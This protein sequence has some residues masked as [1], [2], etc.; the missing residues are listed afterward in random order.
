MFLH[1]WWNFKRFPIPWKLI[2]LAILTSFLVIWA[3]YRFEHGPILTAGSSLS[4][5][6]VGTLARFHPEHREIYWPWLRWPW[7]PANHFVQGLGRAYFNGT[8]GRDSY[9]LG[10]VYSGGHWQFYPVAFLVKT[11]IALLLFF[12]GGCVWLFGSGKWKR[13][14]ALTLLITGFLGPL[15]VGVA[16]NMNFGLRHVLPIYPFVAMIG[17]VG[18][19]ELWRLHSSRAFRLSAQALVLAL[20][21]WNLETCLHAA[22]DLLAYFN[23]PASVHANYFLVDSDLDWG[24]DLKRLSGKLEQLHAKQVS[25][26]YFGS[27]DLSSAHLPSFQVFESGENPGEWFAISETLFM[28]NTGDQWL[29]GYPY[30]RVGKSIRLYHLPPEV[31]SA[32][33]R[34]ETQKKPGM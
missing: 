22:P 8:Q 33:L 17:A 26:D 34:Q 21:G 6:D 2:G 20:L 31:A 13:R 12:L 7:V 30:M 29:K 28:K 15:A 4:G 1:S 27:R 14:P 23:E 11:P 25:M 18:A 5:G 32:S 16:S 9:L 3:G 19:I 24:Q 10:K